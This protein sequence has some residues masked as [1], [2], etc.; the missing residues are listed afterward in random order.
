MTTKEATSNSRDL[1]LTKEVAMLP[2]VIKLLPV[3]TM[4]EVKK[5]NSKEF[6]A[7]ETCV[8]PTLLR[9]KTASLA[10]R[11]VVFLTPPMCVRSVI[12]LGIS[13]SARKMSLLTGHMANPQVTLSYSS[14]MRK[15][16]SVLRRPSTNNT[17][18][19]G[20]STFSSPR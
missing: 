18:E 2:V 6:P 1:P 19:T 7:A 12:S 15:R 11:C 16:L 8:F 5:A 14:K 3:V 17:L 4:V 20:T 9:L 13:A 10:L